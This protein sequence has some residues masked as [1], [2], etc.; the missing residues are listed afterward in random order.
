LLVLQHELV[1]AGVKFSDNQLLKLM[2][3]ILRGIS[4]QVVDQF[5]E[6][7]QNHD[8]SDIGAVFQAIAVYEAH[9][10]P[11]KFP[12]LQTKGSDTEHLHVENA[13]VVDIEDDEKPVID[14]AWIFQSGIAIADWV[15]YSA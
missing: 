5:W 13:V 2:L 11:V 1:D 4:Q 12:S 9:G 14:E 8:Y 3:P 7:V 6:R 10:K 15:M